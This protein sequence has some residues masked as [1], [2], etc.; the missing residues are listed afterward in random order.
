MGIREDLLNYK[1]QSLENPAVTK[2]VEDTQN[3]RN[4]VFRDA[5]DAVTEWAQGAIQGAEEVGRAAAQVGA[6]APEAVTDLGVDTELPQATPEQQQA[7]N[8]YSD[9]SNTFQDETVAPVAVAAALTGTGYG[10]MAMAPFI[11]KKILKDA[12]A[13]GTGTAVTDFALDSIPIYGTYRMTQEEGFSE[14]AEAHPLRA[15]GLALAGEADTVFPVMAT[16]RMARKSYLMKVKKK[17]PAEAEQI[18]TGEFDLKKGKIDKAAETEDAVFYSKTPSE[19]LKAYKRP[20]KTFKA[21]KLKDNEMEPTM[22]PKVSKEVDDLLVEGITKARQQRQADME[23]F[24]DGLGQEVKPLEST[25]TGTVHIN[26]IWKTANSITPIRAGRLRAGKNVL[27][28]FETKTEGIRTR[29]FQ[30]FETIAHE[31]GHFIDKR[32]GLKGADEELIRNATAKWGDAYTPQQRRAEGIAEFTAE[33]MFNPEV[34]KKNFPEYYE[35][36]TKGLSS[37]A[38]LSAKV[39]KLSN[40]IRR[41]HYQSP[42]AQVRGNIS[43]YGD[44]QRSLRDRA[45]KAFTSVYRAWVD[46]TKGIRDVIKDTVGDVE[47]AEDPA[48]LAQAIKSQVPGRIALLL[49]DTNIPTEYAISVL[50]KIYNTPLN[51]VTFKD[52]LAPLKAVSDKPEYKEYL[53]KTGLKDMYEAFNSYITAK[54]FIEIINEMNRRRVEAIDEELK[55]I[56]QKVETLQKEKDVES[57]KTDLISLWERKNILEKKKEAI[58]AGKDDFK[59][60]NPKTA[61]EKVVNEAPSALRRASNRLRNFNNNLL[62]IAVANDLLKQSTAKYFRQTYPYYVPVYRDFSI[63][64]GQLTTI[65]QKAA[66]SYVNIDNFYKSLNKKG[67]DR[68]VVDPLLQMEKATSRLIKNVESNKVAKAV[69]KLAQ[70]E[71]GSDIAIRVSGTNPSAARNIFTV[72]IKGKK[73]AWQVIPEEL[74][75]YLANANKDEA[76]VALDVVRKLAKTS[77]KTLRI[78]ATTSPFYMIANFLKDS[79]F[80]GLSSQTGMK[81]F[82]SALNGF[83]YRKDKELMAKFYAEGVPFSTYVGSNGDITS[84]LRSYSTKE[85][86]VKATKGYKMLSL[87]LDKALRASNA[88][89]EAPRLVE[90]KRM[91]DKGASLDQAGDAARDL[92]LNFARAGTKGR[93]VN[94]YTAFFNA[95]IQGTDKFVRLLEPSR[96]KETLFKGIMYLTLPSLALWMQNKDKDWYRDINYSDKMK[97]WFWEA[98]PDVILRIPKP[99]IAGYI[100]ASVPERIMDMAMTQDVKAT[101]GMSAYLLSNTLPDFVPTPILIAGEVMLNKD[102]YRGRDIVSAK[103]QQKEPKDQYNLY[104]SEVAKGIGQVTGWSPLLIDHALKGQTGSSG[105][106]FLGIMDKVLKDNQTPTRKPTELTRFTHALGKRTRTS[107]VFYDGLDKLEKQYNSRGDRKKGKALEGMRSAKRRVDEYRRKITKV[108]NNASLSGDQKRAKMDEYEAKIQQIQRKANSKYLNYKYIQQQ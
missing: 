34:A 57:V 87:A 29:S 83:M 77:A 107:E 85:T 36:F 31:V 80:A 7:L 16:A 103:D 94:Q 95:A 43:I 101:D 59:T 14:F 96:R 13:K 79:V 75:D 91:L 41:W 106:F 25:L 17:T 49:G 27:G 102:T 52:V 89:E 33:Y 56:Q 11:A 108:L 81:P 37:N 38:D 55:L 74:Y 46:D 86:G 67:S 48:A 19:N 45:D 84:R 62:N 88:F 42:E 28:Y 90:F 63:E 44:Q 60:P 3:L 26:D 93:Q 2:A 65:G 18:V 47:R 50:E 1:R 22:N 5:G 12:E 73:E 15:L 104:T 78:G 51:R 98:A 58:L 39:D 24:K 23:F 20:E 97:Y 54:H 21:T 70:E 105:T 68:A 6:V 64:A 82:F 10:F 32:L 69:V 92:T 71:G 4:S 100:F 8:W 72:W 53:A 35:I 99:D 66:N 30:N 76:Y 9:A 61:Y 40:Q